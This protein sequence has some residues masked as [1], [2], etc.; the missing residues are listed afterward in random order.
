MKAF[1]TG[2]SGFIGGYLA[3]QLLKIGTS[4]T[5]FDKRPLPSESTLDCVFIEGDL[6]NLEQISN[7]LSGGH[8]IVYHLAANADISAGVKDTALDLNLTTIATYNVLESM[9]RGST[10]AIVFLSGSGVY[11]D[12]GATVATE[13]MGP[14]LPVSLYGAGKLAAEG[15]ISAFSSMFGFRATILRPANVVGG[16]QTHGVVFDFINKLKRDSNN[17]QILGD[18]KQTKS[19]LYVGDLYEAVSTVLQSQKDPVS[20]LNI[21]SDDT[22]DVNW[23]A[24]KVI[25]AMKLPN[26]CVTHT[27]GKVGWTGDVP[28]VQLS[29]EKLKK[30]GWRPKYTSKD[31]VDLAIAEILDRY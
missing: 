26:V 13:N 8:D 16:G 18:G 7:A 3:K 12:L 30:T 17:L 22:V 31:A 24:Q 11:G 19:Y 9:R 23:I 25:E 20:L 27:G 6:L 1:I 2:G 5:I 28:M 4:V 14:L 15:L 29:T 10:K 21:A